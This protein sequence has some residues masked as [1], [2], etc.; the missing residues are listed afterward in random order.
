M[1]SQFPEN[2]FSVNFNQKDTAFYANDYVWQK[3]LLS[4]IS[5]PHKTQ[6]GQNT[7]N[8]STAGLYS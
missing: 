7:D 5:V 8:E 4:E 2:T 6:S 3:P 1:K